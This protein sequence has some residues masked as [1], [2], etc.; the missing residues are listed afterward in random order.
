MR[1]TIHRLCNLTAQSEQDLLTLWPHCQAQ[2]LHDW[3]AE[4]AIFV[5]RFNGRELGAL[6]F[7]A[8]GLSQI[9]VHPI[10]RRR[11]VATYLVQDTLR[12][13]GQP[14]PL[15]DHDN[16]DLKALFTALGLA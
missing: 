5:A 6:L 7:D 12:Q 16:A 3:V 1:L 13:L 9:C 15:N 11:G 14:Q 10:T 4:Q 8:Q 2:Q